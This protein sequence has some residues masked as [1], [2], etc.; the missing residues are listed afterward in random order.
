PPAAGASDPGQSRSGSAAGRWCG[1]GAGGPR[2]HRRG[3]GTPAHLQSRARRAAADTAGACGG[4]RP[5]PRLRVGMTGKTAVVL[6]NLGGPDRPGAVRPFLVNLFSD[7]AIIALP[8]PIRFLL[9][10]LIAGRRAKAAAAIYE[11]IGGASPLL[12][13]TRAQADALE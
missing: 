11:K 1:A 10:R 5:S 4:A 3:G 13:N 6:F 12:A 8:G 2:R 7:P 9:A